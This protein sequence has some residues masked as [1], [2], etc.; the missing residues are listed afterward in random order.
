MALL[1][2]LLRSGR[3]RGVPDVEIPLPRQ[4]DDLVQPVAVHVAD[5][6]I[7]DV[8]AAAELGPAERLG[9]GDVVGVEEVA[10]R[11]LDDLGR[12]P[13]ADVG[14]RRAGQELQVLHVMREARLEVAGRREPGVDVIVGG[15]LLVGQDDREQAPDAGGGRREAE[16]SAAGE[17]AE[18]ALADRRDRGHVR[19]GGGAALRLHDPVV[20]ALVI[21]IERGA[22]RVQEIRRTGGGEDARLERAVAVDVGERRRRVDALADVR[23]DLGGE[24]GDLRRPAGEEGPAAVVVAVLV[25]GVDAR[26]RRVRRPGRRQQLGDRHA[27]A[28]RE[29]GV[30][31]LVVLLVGADHD[32]ERAVV[33][34]VAD[35]RRVHDLLAAEGAVRR[36]WTTVTSARERCHLVGSRIDRDAGGIGDHDREA[37]PRVAEPVPHVEVPVVGA[38]DDVQATVAVEV[39]E[40]GRG[41]DRAVDAVVAVL[42]GADPHGVRRVG[43]GHVDREPGFQHAL[44]I[45]GV[46]GLAKQLLPLVSHVKV[47]VVLPD[48]H[49]ERRLHLLEDL[50]A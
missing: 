36:P 23:E 2:P 10:R 39:G 19:A 25:D 8:P 29:R 46:Y 26:V 31:R 50:L 30:D 6:R 40:R 15:E 43:V 21:A 33:V 14:D 45:P 12:R 20:A 47:P 7:G 4:R 1:R 37:G 49:L 42:V 3:R 27:G 13:A 34:D 41:D 22:V 28:A 16:L 32:V 5:G 38:D 44:V 24:E 35:R 17:V 11:A 48:H 9:A 18:C